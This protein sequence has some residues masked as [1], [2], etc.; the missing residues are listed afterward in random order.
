MNKLHLLIASAML[1]VGILATPAA[2]VDYFKCKNKKGLVHV[3]DSVDLSCKDLATKGKDF[4]EKACKLKEPSKDGAP[5]A[6]KICRKTCETCTYC[7]NFY[8]T[9]V[10]YVFNNIYTYPPGC[11]V[12][13]WDYGEACV[14]TTVS[15]TPVPLYTDKNTTE[16]AGVSL[17]AAGNFVTPTT[18]LTHGA[19]IFKKKGALHFST[20]TDIYSNTADA[21]ATGG[22]GVFKHAN[23]GGLLTLYEPTSTSSEGLAQY[24]VCLYYK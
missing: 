16:S 24:K 7:E 4:V 20:I 17:I 1:I 8:S 10:G 12:T 21:T 23:G 22:T 9:Y 19:F 6:R 5:P 2:A 15:V 18:S 14:G 11:N 3:G 13:V